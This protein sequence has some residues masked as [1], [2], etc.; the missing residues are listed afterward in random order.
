MPHDLLPDA[1]DDER[2]KD[3][4]LFH[5]FWQNSE[6]NPSRAAVLGQRIAAD[7]ERPGGTPAPLHGRGAWPLPDAPAVRTDVWARRASTRTFGPQPATL[8]ELG[9]LLHPLRARPDGQTRLLPSGGAKYPLQAYVAL[10]RLEGPPA[11]SRQ[12]AWYD[13]ARHGL[14]P[15]RPCP[16]WPELA[17]ALAVDWT[18]E[19]AAVV[20]LVA[21]AETMLAKY[22]E[23]GGRFLLIEAGTQLGALGYQVADA[24]WA[25][26]AIGSFHDDALLAL[27]GLQAPRH[28]AVL[29]YA[30]GPQA[31]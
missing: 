21:Q 24:G 5:L 15:L 9:R 16:P 3:A 6:L 27:L 11:L 19:P 26:C 12:I 14:A 20:M 17:R 1:A 8:D 10:C 7:A 22:G 28:L 25:G 2:W 31:R 30:C 13:N 18:D 4:P 29:A 23:R